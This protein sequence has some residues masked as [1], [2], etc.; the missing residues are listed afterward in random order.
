MQAFL[1]RHSYRG[2]KTAAD[3]LTR[4]RST[5]TA[6]VGLPP[7]VLASLISAQVQLLRTLQSTVADLSSRP[8]WG[9]VP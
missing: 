9:A 8:R 7:A 1:R 5:P 2:G 6:P 4:L 3:L